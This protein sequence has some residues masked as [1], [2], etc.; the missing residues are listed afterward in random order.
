MDEDGNYSVTIEKTYAT[1][2][3][4]KAVFEGTDEAI[5]RG[6]A[7]G[8]GQAVAVKVSKPGQDFRFDVPVI[9]PLTLEAGA[10]AGLSALAVEAG[11]TLLVQP[12]AHAQRSGT[13]EQRLR[14]GKAADAQHVVVERP[15]LRLAPVGDLAERRA[16]VALRG[17]AQI[18]MGVEVDDQQ[19]LP[20]R[21]R[22]CEALERAPGDFVSAAHHQRAAALGHH[23]AYATGQRLLRVWSDSLGSR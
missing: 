15:A 19:A 22:A 13:A 9:G 14:V 8:R 1:G 23:V 11:R 17:H 7:L 2:T 21:V 4:F 12:V 18:E 10:S 20:V 5:K 16:R 6:A 3:K